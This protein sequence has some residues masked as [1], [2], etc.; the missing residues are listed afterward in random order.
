M[1]SIKYFILALLIPC[2]VIGDTPPP[3]YQVFTST[4]NGLVP[5][6]GG[7]TTNFLRADGTWQAAGGGSPT[8]T[9][10]TIGYFNNSGALASSANFRWNATN[11]WLVASTLGSGATT[12]NVGIGSSN[13]AGFVMGNV[14]GSGSILSTN[15]GVGNI[16]FGDSVS[17]AQ[18]SAQGNGSLV[19]G[20]ATG[21]GILATELD[22]SFSMG[23]A[24]TSGQVAANGTATFAFGYSDGSSI[25]GANGSGSEAFG[26]ATS[27][28]TIDTTAGKFGQYAGGYSATTG[29]IATSGNG[30]FTFG[31]ADGTG[32]LAASG[33][34]SFTL[35]RAHG[36]SITSSGIGSIATGYASSFGIT[37]GGNG[38]FAGGVP[39]TAALN[40]SGQAA[41]VFGD[42]NTGSGINSTTLGLGQSNGSYASIV[43][44]RYAD[45]SGATAGSWVSTDPLFVLGNGTGTGAR[46]NAFKVLKN[47]N[48]TGSAFSGTLFTGTS[49][50]GQILAPDGGVSTPGV[51]FANELNSGMY[52]VGS[53]E[54]SLS[55][56]GAQVMDLQ[57]STSG[58]GNIGMGGAASVSD[59]YPLLIQRS[60]VSVGTDAQIAN[61][62]TNAF[63]AAK[64]QLSTDA[65]NNLGEVG[66]FTSATTLAAYAGAMTVRPNGLTNMLSLIGGDLSTG[67]VTTFTAGDYAATGET[68]R[69]N[70]DHTAQFMQSVTT[71]T[72]PSAGLKFY[73][74]AGVFSSKTSGGT[75]SSFAGANTGDVTIGTGNGLSLSGQALSLQLATGSVPGALSAADWTTFNGKA[76]TVVTT[77]GDILTFSTVPARL[78]VGTNTF[79]LTADSTQ[80][81]GLKW[82]APAG[83]GGGITRSVSSVSTSTAMGS[84]ALTDYVYLVSGA[85]VTMT[86]PTAVGNTNRYSV[87]RTGSSNITIAT[88]SAQ[89]IDGSSSVTITVQY[90]DLEF[91]SDG[92]NWNIL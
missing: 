89:T 14:T 32:S 54:I 34:G 73:N 45:I 6:S 91:I 76:S 56:V 79:V 88:T 46:A 60:N 59:S 58:F 83:G 67:Y 35:G 3:V 42:G 22:G 69:F 11:G 8:G 31:Y 28:S 2:L 72:S 61:P 62:D 80:T 66:I 37:A 12:G 48:V 18:I 65:G 41:F 15:F 7:G 16:A 43:G 57:K 55:V 23:R 25:V 9:A 53:G 70:A 50:A 49:F 68:T 26:Y 51:A 86:L 4:K 24:D 52:R 84:T 64:W 36:V 29:N 20:Y 63:S 44:G 78:P 5:L 33:D 21:S 75:V 39:A 13:G 82:A 87:K 47:G 90:Q 77:K 81:T 27:N 92:A 17:S 85:G 71:P 30:A 1:N 19:G 38:S 10:N 40:A 74:N